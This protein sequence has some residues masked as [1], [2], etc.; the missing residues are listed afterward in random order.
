[1]PSALALHLSPAQVAQRVGDALRTGKCPPEREFDRFLPMELRSV[2]TTYW[3]RLC[4][5]LRAAEWIR[6]LGIKSVVDVGSG[7]GKF[8]VVAGL[9]TEARFLGVEQ[10]ERL[11]RSA[12]DLAET[13]GVSDRVRFIR[14]TFGEMPLPVAEA[15]YFFNPFG[16]NIFGPEDRL[17]HDVEL[18][19]SRYLRDVASAEQLLDDLPSDTYLITY[20]GFGGEVPKAF[21]D[22]RVDRELPSVLRMW[23]KVDV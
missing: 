17:D 8:C 3:S 12:R 9:A 18:G 2:S 14:G 13:F 23:R 21:R 22:V 7:P 10:R 20:N 4:V 6:E 16:E 1:M 15:Y 19:N 11:V 5:A